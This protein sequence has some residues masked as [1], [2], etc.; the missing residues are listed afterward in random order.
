MWTEFPEKAWCSHILPHAHDPGWV[1]DGSDIPSI[2]LKKRELFGLI[3]FAHLYNEQGD[4]WRVGYDSSQPEP[5]DGY[6]TDGEHLIRIE[7]KIIVDQ[8]PGEVLDEM[9]AT[10]DKYRVSRKG[11]SYGKD[12]TL[13]I[14]P[15][16]APAHGGL[17]K[18][19][20]LGKEID[21]LAKTVGE[22]CIFERVYTLSQMAV[23]G[24]VGR[25]H[26]VQHFP[27][28]VSKDAQLD[29]D[30][31]TGDADCPYCNLDL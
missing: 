28:S 25:W 12:R 14:Q 1:K 18:I 7:H 9:I 17:V 4:R 19:S 31:L 8:S 5:N 16:K 2:G 22:A 27:R 13:I 11:A 26:I 3:I 23:D 6:I 20:D 24:N 10:Y 21:N 30:Y 15:N 29:F